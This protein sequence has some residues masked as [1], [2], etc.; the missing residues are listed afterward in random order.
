MYT[1][2]I[3]IIANVSLT[4]VRFFSPLRTSSYGDPSSQLDLLSNYCVIIDLLGGH[5][6]IPHRHSS[7]ENPRRDSNFCKFAKRCL[8]EYKPFVRSLLFPLRTSSRG[9]PDQNNSNRHGRI[10][11]VCTLIPSFLTFLP[12]LF[13]SSLCTFLLSDY[14][15]I[16]NK[17]EERK[18]AD[19]LNREGKIA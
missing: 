3:I 15:E 19:I 9:S 11:F 7:R 1:A 18:V 4:G 10:I 6:F 14:F 8:G 17:K 5:F 12:S 16:R 2:I 13:T